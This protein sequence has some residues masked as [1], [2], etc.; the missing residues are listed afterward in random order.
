[1]QFLFLSLFLLSSCAALKDGPTQDITVN[2]TDSNAP[3]T[4]CLAITKDVK[5]DFFAPGKVTVQRS[6]KPLQ[7]ECNS[8]NGLMAYTVLEPKVN[9]AS[10]DNIYNL[11][12]GLPYDYFSMS[13][14][15]YPEIVLLDFSPEIEAIIKSSPAKRYPEKA[16]E[17]QFQKENSAEELSEKAY[18][19]FVLDK[20]N[21]KTPTPLTKEPK[22]QPSL[23]K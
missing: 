15:E 4:K 9:D 11:G 21:L 14:W 23:N 5:K 6:E 8:A 17:E 13:I 2:F 18:D 7:I 19:L 20:S 22:P 12:L 1:M 3:Q 10:L 16:Y